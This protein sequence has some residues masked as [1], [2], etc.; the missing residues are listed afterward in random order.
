MI[1]IMNLRVS[2]SSGIS[3]PA[4]LSA[5]DVVYFISLLFCF[6]LF[7]SID[8]GTGDMLHICNI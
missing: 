1:T 2:Q 6:L 5:N 7:G 3:S 4:Q 8:A